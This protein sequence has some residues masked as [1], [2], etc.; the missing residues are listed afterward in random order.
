MYF[1]SILL[2]MLNVVSEPS[3]VK[4]NIDASIAEDEIVGHMKY[5]QN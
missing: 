3:L 4:E 1:V 2:Y 5:L